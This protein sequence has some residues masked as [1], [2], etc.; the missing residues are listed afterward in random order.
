MNKVSDMTPEQLFESADAY[1]LG[2]LEE[3]ET[4]A[5]ERGMQAASS[6]VRIQLREHMRRSTL[7]IEAT[8]PAV[9]PD[10][11]LRFRIFTAIREAM[12][13]TVSSTQKSTSWWHS[14]AFWRAACLGFATAAVTLGGFGFAM[15]RQHDGLERSIQ[16]SI[17]SAESQRLGPAFARV[18]FSDDRLE[19]DLA[20]IASLSNKCEA[21]LFVD[22]VTHSAV[23]CAFDMPVNEAIYRVEFRAEDGSIR[24]LATFTGTSGLNPITLAK[25]DVSVIGEVVVVGPAAADRPAEDIFRIKVG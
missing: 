24:N 3:T 11:G 9:E 1:V 2:L 6:E 10:A 12:I 23:L 7:G 21:R 14:T 18:M 20:P 13:G 16:A 15:Q 25:L 8:L 17:V 22:P 4:D 5:F 19:V